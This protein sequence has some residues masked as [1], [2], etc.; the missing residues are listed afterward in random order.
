MMMFSKMRTIISHTLKL[1]Y[2][3]HSYCMSPLPTVL[4]LWNI[5]VHV[6]STNCCNK[7]FNIEPLI[8]DFFSIWPTLGV[9]YINLD[10]GYVGFWGYL[11]DLW[12]R[13]ENNIIEQVIVL[14]YVFDII[15]WNIAIG[16]L[17]DEW[18]SYDFE[19]GFGLW[20]SRW[21]NLF[22]I[23]RKWVLNVFFYFLKVRTQIDS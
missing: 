14:E 15:Q 17:V 7:A 2:M 3:T 8:Y 16:F 20:K 10:D 19:V 13:C 11:N 4:A 12:F 6:C 9:P 22:C 23:W 21:W 18:N 1:L 5:W